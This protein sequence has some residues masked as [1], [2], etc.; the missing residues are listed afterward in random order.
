MALHHEYAKILKTLKEVDGDNIQQQF[1]AL[2]GNEKSPKPFSIT[3]RPI[4]VDYLLSLLDVESHKELGLSEEK[5]NKLIE[6]K[7]R[8]E[9]EKLEN[10]QRIKELLA[11]EKLEKEIL[12]KEKLEKEGKDD[13]ILKLQGTI[14]D[15][16]Q[17]LNM[18]G[19][20]LESLNDQ[21][22]ALKSLSI[23]DNSKFNTLLTKTKDEISEL[24]KSHADEME[25]K[26]TEILLLNNQLTDRL[27]IQTELN[28]SKEENT[29]INMYFNK[30]QL[31][32]T[33]LASQ[34]R[35]A[36]DALTIITSNFN[37]LKEAQESLSSQSPNI[38]LESSLYECPSPPPEIP[39][40]LQSNVPL[41]L[42]EILTRNGQIFDNKR[43]P[44][45]GAMI[46]EIKALRR[47]KPSLKFHGFYSQQR[48]YK[49]LM[50]HEINLGNHEKE[51][52]LSKTADEDSMN[53]WWA[54][55]SL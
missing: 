35:A 12:A 8:L 42:E 39:R 28:N 46:D 19:H 23:I 44:H 11:K 18:E 37:A 14:E 7:T 31:E 27:K 55:Y 10:E 5:I 20:N 9:G 43:Y 34:L 15:L 36:K 26:T 49:E 32:N 41:I 52:L 48:W 25:K 22:N 40:P 21:L 54:R 17:K 33:S 4:D 3:I 51:A 47:S 30:L 38:E 2:Y 1:R 45:E 24:T 16:T 29:K 13:K 53:S 6:E 50:L